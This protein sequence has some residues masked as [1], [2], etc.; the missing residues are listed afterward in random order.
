MIEGVEDNNEVFVR[1][2]VAGADLLGPDGMEGPKKRV[3]EL[4]F[5]RRFMLVGSASGGGTCFG[6]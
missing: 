6:G 5:S 1:G 3:A 2:R 4:K